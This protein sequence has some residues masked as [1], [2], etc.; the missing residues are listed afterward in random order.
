MS[1]MSGCRRNR[2][3]LI[4]HRIRMKRPLAA[5]S[6][7]LAVTGG[8]LA[9]ADTSAHAAANLSV[10]LSAFG[11]GTDAV[12]DSAGNPVLTVGVPES[13]AQVK[14]NN[15][16]FDAPADAPVFLATNATGS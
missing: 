5:A 3:E 8:L 13:S 14:I 10:T 11:T 7:V 6:V 9:I 1:G 16:P 2:R 4:M 15:A 12:W